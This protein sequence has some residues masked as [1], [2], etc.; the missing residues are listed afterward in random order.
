MVDDIIVEVH[1]PAQIV[2]EINNQK[3]LAKYLYKL[4]E[5]GESI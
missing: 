2:S 3:Q 5:M 1:A 4:M